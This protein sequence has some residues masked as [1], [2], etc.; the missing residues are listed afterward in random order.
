MPYANPT[1][2][3]EYQKKYNKDWYLKNKQKN[4]LI[5][6]NCG[7]IFKSRYPNQKYCS[8]KCFGSHTKETNSVKCLVCGNKIFAPPSKGR[9]YCSLKCFGVSIKGVSKNSN[10]GRNNKDWYE[11]LKKGIENRN[12]SK[13]IKKLKEEKGEKN[14][15]WKGKNVKYKGLHMWV[16]N[17]FSKEGVCELCG[18]SGRT[19]WSNKKH[20]YFR[21]RG[22]WQEVCPKCHAKYDIEHKLRFTN[23]QA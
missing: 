4:K 5:C 3:K 13:I 18:K 2:R 12:N 11:A 23:N 8:L 9:R 22:D 19:E 21:N 14:R 1:K 16:S 20:T 10:L 6:E 15:N 7:E 17:N